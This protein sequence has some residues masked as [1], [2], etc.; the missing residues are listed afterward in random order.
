MLEPG[1][2]GPPSPDV[3]LLSVL[4]GDGYLNVVV[5]DD[6]VVHHYELDLADG[7]WFESTI[8]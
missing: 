7:A 6:G 8:P 3:A 4:C 5:Y 2:D 1:P